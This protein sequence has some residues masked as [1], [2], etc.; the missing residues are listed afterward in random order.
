MNNFFT[1]N[2]YSRTYSKGKSFKFSI[3]NSRDTYNNDEFVQDFVQYNKKLWACISSNP[4]TNIPPYLSDDKNKPWE[5]VLEGVSDVEFKQVEN[6]IQWKYEDESEWKTLFELASVT[7]DEIVDML[8]GLD[9]GSNK[10]DEYLSDFKIEI[11][12]DVNSKVKEITSKEI[13]KIVDSAP[14]SHDTLKELSDSI[15]EN[16]NKIETS[17]QAIEKLEERLEEVK[18]G[19]ITWTDVD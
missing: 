9:I 1:N 5:L 7:R 16:E 15:Q 2:N 17:N 13:S 11:L 3:W 14:E 12:S 19:D 18:I 6:N 4:V 10:L 8:K